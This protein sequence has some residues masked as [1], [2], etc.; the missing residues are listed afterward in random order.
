MGATVR[1]TVTAS[2]RE[3]LASVRG[4]AVKADLRAQVSTSP[5]RELAGEA[6]RRTHGK[7]LVA[8]DVVG[9]SESQFGRLVNEGDLKL[10]HLEALGPQTLAALG[11]ELVEAYSA[12]DTPIARL[13]DIWRRR[14]DLDHEEEQIVEGLVP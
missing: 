4:V 10:K 14:R 2:H 9:V 12:L 3:E 5:L 1:Q 8:A 6:I 7:A 11:R 13:R